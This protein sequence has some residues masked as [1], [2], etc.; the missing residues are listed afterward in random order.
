[1]K[2]SKGD[3]LLILVGLVVMVVGSIHLIPA[4]E[5]STRVFGSGSMLPTINSS[6]IVTVTSEFNLTEGEIYIYRK[7]ARL[8]IHRLVCIN[9]DGLLFFKGD[10]NNATDSPITKDKVVEKV[11]KIENSRGLS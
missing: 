4:E 6:S 1:M 11:I 2:Y 3:T 9:K 7:A 10:A 8:V 5:R